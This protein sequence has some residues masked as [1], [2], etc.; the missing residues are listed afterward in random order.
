MIDITNRTEILV[1]AL[2]ISNSLKEV[3]IAKILK[4][5]IPNSNPLFEWK[6]IAAAINSELTAYI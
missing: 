4:P 2:G 5:I 3:K 1:V 6:V